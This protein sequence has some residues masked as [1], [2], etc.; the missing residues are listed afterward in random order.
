MIPRT[1]F[2][3]FQYL[4]GSGKVVPEHPHWAV[5]GF[6]AEKKN[7]KKTRMS[8][9]IFLEEDTIKYLC[10]QV[11]KLKI[12]L[13][14]YLDVN[15]SFPRCFCVVGYFLI[16]PLAISM[17]SKRSQ[18]WLKPRQIQ[19]FPENPIVGG[20]L[21]SFGTA[22]RPSKWEEGVPKSI[23]RGKHPGNNLFTSR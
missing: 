4:S 22:L 5:T 2:S 6:S 19:D 1:L 12:I 10:D 23:P 3:P 13:G 16:P 8:R 15:D 17:A 9:N 14:T 7:E 20:F 21:S 11:L 18:I